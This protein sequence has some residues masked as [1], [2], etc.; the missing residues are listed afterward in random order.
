MPPS[1]LCPL[2]F[3][4]RPDQGH[5]PDK[6]LVALPAGRSP[7]S[8]RAAKPER[9]A[10][11]VHSYRMPCLS[12]RLCTK[13]RVS[14]LDTVSTGSDSDLVGD[15]HAIFSDDL[16]LASLTRSLSLPVLTVSTIDF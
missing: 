5:S 3:G 4:L 9:K 13:S 2:I 16:S 8:H 1:G 11:T 15:Q 7:A 6:F 10:S 12:R 14:R